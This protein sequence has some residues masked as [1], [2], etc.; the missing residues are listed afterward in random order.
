MRCFGR[1]HRVALGVVHELINDPENNID[2]Q[3]VPTTEQLGDIFTKALNPAAFTRAVAMIGMKR[4][5]DVR[6]AAD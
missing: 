4:L 2:M 1:T 3:H 6:P 5:R